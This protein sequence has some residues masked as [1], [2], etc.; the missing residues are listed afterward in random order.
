MEVHAPLAPLLR[1]MSE[2]DH[3]IIFN[4]KQPPSG[5]YDLHIPMLSLPLLFE[6][7]LST[8]PDQVPYIKPSPKAI[9][10]W[11]TDTFSE[12]ELWV[13]MVWFGSDTDPRRICPLPLIQEL[14][15]VPGVRFFSLQ[16]NPNKADIEILRHNVDLNHWGD[17]LN[18]FDDTA[19]AI[20]HLDLILFVQ[21][22][23]QCVLEGFL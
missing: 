14:M 20:H 18:D 3:V 15:T 10:R 9:S 2:V 23:F 19:A 5:R 7:T 17:R 21:V 1:Q 22:L 6:T 16:I 11:Q 12:N 8:I 4:H 13:G